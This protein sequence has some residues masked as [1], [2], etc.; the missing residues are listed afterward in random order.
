MGC[1]VK[2]LLP[3]AFFLVFSENRYETLGKCPFRKEFAQEIGYFP[4]HQKYICDGAGAEEYSE[5]LI[6]YESQNPG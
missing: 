6:A 1:Q 3:R 4:R 5:H 2:Q